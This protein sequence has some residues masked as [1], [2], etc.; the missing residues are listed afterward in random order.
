MH[1]T[2]VSAG[3]P[4]P[5]DTSSRPGLRRARPARPHHFHSSFLLHHHHGNHGLLS[6]RRGVMREIFSVL[7]KN[8]LLN[9]S[10]KDAADKP[11]GAA[12]A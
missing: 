11:A 12:L 10:F 4:L 9:S 3:A 8:S 7:R 5:L 6:R 1:D 2:E